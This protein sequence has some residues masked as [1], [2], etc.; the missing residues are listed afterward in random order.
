MRRLFKGSNYGVIWNKSS[1]AIVYEVNRPWKQ[2]TKDVIVNDLNPNVKISADV[3][4]GLGHIYKRGRVVSHDEKKTTV[5][6]PPN[7]VSIQGL[8]DVEFGKTTISVKFSSKEGYIFKDQVIESE[9]DMRLSVYADGS[10]KIL[11]K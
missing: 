3:E 6:V 8:R 5:E 1:E 2:I 11:K 7:G 10:T 4:V 9:A